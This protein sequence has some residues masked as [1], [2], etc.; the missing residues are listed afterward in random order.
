MAWILLK[1]NFTF[2]RVSRIKLEK[3]NLSANT[4]VEFTNFYSKKKSL[5][6]MLIY[7]G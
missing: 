3:C 5:F 6:L 2:A 7:S 4:W 1:N